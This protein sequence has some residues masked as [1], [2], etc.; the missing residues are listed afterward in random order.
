MA[1]LF[2]ILLSLVIGSGFYAFLLFMVFRF[3]LPRVV[4]AVLMWNINLF[5]FLGRGDPIGYMP[6]GA[7]IYDGSVGLLGMTTESILTGFIIYPAWVFI[8]L[9][10]FRWLRRNTDQ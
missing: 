5:S 10:V 6:N 7:P 9:S 8:W 3:R 1:I 4:K 2:R